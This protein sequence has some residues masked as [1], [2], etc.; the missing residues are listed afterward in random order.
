MKPPVEVLHDEDAETPPEDYSSFHVNV[1]ADED[2]FR[3][4]RVF[5]K[6][7]EEAIKVALR[8]AEDLLDAVIVVGG[9][10]SGIPDSTIMDKREYELD[11][12]FSE[13]YRPDVDLWDGGPIKQYVTVEWSPSD[14]HWMAFHDSIEEALRYFNQIESPWEPQFIQDLDND[15]RF[16]VERKTFLVHKEES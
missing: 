4:Y 12:L 11:A 14:E 1:L 6:S 9:F 10:E 5:A 7:P 16:D 2:V 8:Q 3:A 15:E 13:G